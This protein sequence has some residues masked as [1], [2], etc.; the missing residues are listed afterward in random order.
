[1]CGRYTLTHPEQ[2]KEQYNIV[3]HEYNIAPNYN[4]APTQI[5]PIIHNDGKDKHLELMKWGLIPSWSKEPV[6]KFSTINARAEGLEDKPT[7]RAS[8]KRRR[9]LVPAD[10]FYEW[11]KTDDGKQPYYIKL[12]NSDLFSFAG[13]WDSWHSP[14]GSKLH[15]YTIVTTTPNE[16]MKEIHDRMPVI[17]ERQ[18]EEAWLNPDIEDP[19]TLHS[20]L[21]PYNAT[22]MEAFPVSKSVNNVKNNQA[23]LIGPI[24]SA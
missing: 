3:E 7:Y 17:L 12:K 4:A 16:L 19:I 10:G 5:M 24:N 2:I 6:M 18:H 23:D 8:F 11:K 21:K 9:C 15:T 14:D 22:K 1:M 13:L 20:F